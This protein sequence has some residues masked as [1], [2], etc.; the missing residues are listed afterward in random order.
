MG[1]IRSPMAQMSKAGHLHLMK[2]LQ[3]G[4]VP[5][6]LGD[7]QRKL[8]EG[9]GWGP[10]SAW[11]GGPKSLTSRSLTSQEWVQSGLPLRGGGS[12][13]VQPAELRAPV[14]W[15]AEGSGSEAL[16]GAVWPPTL[17][18]SL[19]TAPPSRSRP[20]TPQDPASSLPHLAHCPPHLD[21]HLPFLPPA[22]NA[23]AL[24]SLAS[25]LSPTVLC[26][27]AGHCPS[28]KLIP[29]PRTLSSRGS[30]GKLGRL[31]IQA[32][33]WRP[34]LMARGLGGGL[35]RVQIPT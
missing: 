30:F 12:R 11:T 3:A 5:G 9:Q 25:E 26:A 14:G 15:G 21:P 6:C 8:L 10:R 35:T 31:L 2:F 20:R 16:K 33:P 32:Q 19:C 1:T 18:S 22:G 29:S 28:C 24:P 17:S 4:P 27:S 23:L 7:G 34:R 13:P